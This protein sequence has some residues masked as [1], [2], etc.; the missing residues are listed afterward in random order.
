MTELTDFTD[1]TPD[2][3][4][5]EKN[6]L[7]TAGA[8]EHLITLCDAE[9]EVE[10]HSVLEETKKYLREWENL[11][12]ETAEDFNHVGGHFYSAM[13]SGDLYNAYRRA[14]GTNR[15]LLLEVFG[16]HHINQYKPTHATKV[17]V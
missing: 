7:R 14:D 10:R 15:P 1:P 6:L 17:E 16:A 13:W 3:T 4:S 8:S 9:V 5:D 11:T 12:S 2:L